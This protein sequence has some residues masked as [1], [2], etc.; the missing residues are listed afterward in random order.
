[1]KW[2]KFLWEGVVE[3]FSVPWEDNAYARPEWRAWEREPLRTPAHYVETWVYW[4]LDR[5]GTPTVSICDDPMGHPHAHL[6]RV[7]IPADVQKCSAAVKAP[8]LCMVMTKFGKAEGSCPQS[9]NE[10]ETK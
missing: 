6:I 4:R 2:L 8:P 3:A 1:M 7:P 10:T 9:S 5:D